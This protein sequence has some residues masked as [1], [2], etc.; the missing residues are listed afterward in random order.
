M[1][2]V[3]LIFSNV[4]SRHTESFATSLALISQLNAYRQRKK[5]LFKQ[6]R[7]G[8][9]GMCIAIMFLA[10]L[11]DYIPTKNRQYRSKGMSD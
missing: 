8:T 3:H 5:I 7:Y 4:F 2:A 9:I 11:L 1:Q 6:I 10:W